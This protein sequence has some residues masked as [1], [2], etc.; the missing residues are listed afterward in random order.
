MAANTRARSAPPTPEPATSQALVL[1]NEATAATCIGCGKTSDQ[2]MWGQYKVT[3]TPD[4]TQILHRIPLGQGC[5]EC[6]DLAYL[7][8]LPAKK[9]WDELERDL[10]RD[11]KLK[12]AW[13]EWQARRGG[14]VARFPKHSVN[15]TTRM[16]VRWEEAFTPLP[17][18]SD[19]L[20]G[21]DP[22]AIPGLRVDTIRDVNG[23]PTPVIL[24]RDPHT[25]TTK[26]HHVLR[27]R[28]KLHGTPLDT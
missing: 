4:R 3:Y 9:S 5:S 16:G 28:G 1:Y 7:A 10:P 12:A 20:R 19:V 23:K 22:R 11:A 6:R 13:R 14:K 27:D 2:V 15:E 8:H 26:T 25:H 21:T 17:L 24:T 18:T